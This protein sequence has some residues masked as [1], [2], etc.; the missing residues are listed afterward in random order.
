MGKNSKKREARREE[1]AAAMSE[2]ILVLN[3]GTVAYFGTPK[4]IFSHGEELVSMGLNVP[5]FTKI[6][7]ELKKRGFHPEEAYTVEA[8]ADQIASLLGGGTAL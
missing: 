1:L 2:R 5:A 4:E 6:I 3:H 7:L 8:A